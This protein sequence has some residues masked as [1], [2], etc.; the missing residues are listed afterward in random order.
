MVHKNQ[1][2]PFPLPFASHLKFLQYFKITQDKFKFG[3]TWQ[4]TVEEKI[5]NCSVNLKYAQL[6]LRN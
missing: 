1:L 5:L 2:P 4:P 3:R 6:H